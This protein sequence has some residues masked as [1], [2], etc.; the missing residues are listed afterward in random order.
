M[1]QAADQQFIVSEDV[2]RQSPTVCQFLFVFL[3]GLNSYFKNRTKQN[4]IYLRRVQSKQSLFH[5]QYHKYNNANSI[6]V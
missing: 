2:K 4:I 6:T 5:I 3:F 1:T